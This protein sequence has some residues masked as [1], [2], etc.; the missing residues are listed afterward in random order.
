[1]E[2]DSEKSEGDSSF[3]DRKYR[4]QF[5]LLII[6]VLFFIAPSLLTIFGKP[7]LPKEGDI[8]QE[9]IISPIN[10]I[11]LKEEDSLRAEIEA[12]RNSVPVVLIYN[13][14]IVD[15][16]V[17]LFKE[18]W[19]ISESLISLR[20]ISLSKK[21]KELSK[22]WPE[23]SNKITE[24][25][26]LL[27]NPKDFG[28]IIALGIKIPYSDGFVSSKPIKNE[29]IG[30]ALSIIRNKKE[31]KL[32][33][34]MVSTDSTAIAELGDYFSRQYVNTTDLAQLSL[35][36]SKN[37]L[38][39]N[40]IADVEE[41]ERRRW[42]ACQN[43]SNVS[44]EVSKGEKI[45]GKHEKI[46]HKAYRKIYALYSEKQSQNHLASS[47]N[48]YIVA[49]G[50]MFLLFLVLLMYAYLVYSGWSKIWKDFHKFLVLTAPIAIVG[51][52]SSLFYEEMIPGL[53]L[54]NF[55]IPIN[56][57]VIVAFL[58]FEQRL[59]FFTTLTAILLVSIGFFTDST[60]IIA[61]LLF[62]AIVI[63]SE[64][65]VTVRVKLFAHIVFG[66][67][68]AIFAIVLINYARFVPYF[69]A[70][71]YALSFLA[72][73]MIS[74]PFALLVIPFAE[75]FAG[76]VSTTTLMELS[77]VNTNLLQ[78][79][80][81]EAPGTFTHSII[82]GNMAAAGAEE[83]GANSLLA[84]VGGYYHDIGKLSKPEFFSENE[85]E[86]SLHSEL[87][88]EE[89]RQIIALHVIDGYQIGKAYKLPKPILDIIQRHHGN[90]IIEFFYELAKEQ[91]LSANPDDFRYPGPRPN[92][93]ESSVIMICDILEA[94]F[95]SRGSELYNNRKLSEEYAQELIWSK[96]ED[97]QLD[98][99]PL[100]IGNIKKILPRILPM[101]LRAYHTR[102]PYKLLTN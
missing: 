92:T 81:V 2:E 77:D 24:R 1:M 53:A 26:A 25:L 95:R 57:V 32:P 47:I 27:S 54:N 29:S 36:I 72:S 22:L 94:A 88:P 6:V 41:T 93:I 84:R 79:L 4:K 75:R 16:S 56:F 89:S 35:E 60:F 43:I 55:A 12:V 13:S 9:N 68:A 7:N 66:T 73:V 38:I 76:L 34:S 58:L 50:V 10:F 101:V 19:S 99:S 3:L 65:I 69:D 49:L 86:T 100:T 102:I 90:S 61:T 45:I 11:V 20:N 64:K 28:R 31:K 52:F 67:I 23:L 48:K 39:P 17:K 33:A 91:K 30:N 80:S 37:F 63:F 14:S 44:F 42:N 82:V 83:I 78:K 46:D 87:S 40:L 5:I 70:L 15:S 71:N 85:I 59:A 18:R 96:I 62:S 97:G 98:E 8:A 51:L 21:K 74:F